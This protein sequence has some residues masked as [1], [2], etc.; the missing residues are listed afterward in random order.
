MSETIRIYL[1]VEGQTEQTFVR[2]I[3]AP[4]MAQ[5][6][7]FLEARLLGKSGHK[8]GNV[9]FERMLKDVGLL[10]KQ[11]ANTYVTTMMDYFRIDNAWPGKKEVGR[12]VQL[13]ETLTAQERVNILEEAT[14]QEV[15]KNFATYHA[16]ERFLPYV[17]IHEFESLLFSDAQVLA[18]KIEVKESAINAILQQYNGQPEEINSEPS[19]APSKQILSLCPSY[20]KVVMGSV[21][22]KAIGIQTIRQSCPHFNQWLTNMEAL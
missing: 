21:I 10:L 6:G 14:A 17:E 2:D 11:E 19:K 7:I 22:A 9:T 3:L 12:R 13:G 20:R 4:E 18:H 1:V 15:S 8:G 16:S 5:K